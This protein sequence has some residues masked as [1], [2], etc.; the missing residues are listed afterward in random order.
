MAFIIPTILAQGIYT[1]IIGTISSVTIGTCTLVKSI[2]T[3]QNPNVNNIIKK[4]DIERRLHLIQAV[5]NMI[6]KESNTKMANIKLNNLEK[7]EIFEMVGSKIDLMTDPIELCLVYLHEI[8]Q[9]IH[10][11]LTAI[12]KK[13][14]YHNTKWFSAWR[15]LNIEPLVDN[16]KTNSDLLEN[17]FNDLTKISIFLKNK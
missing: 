6:D 14:T 17:R 8:I 15:T 11:D 12:N 4:M 3:H 13:V 10:K 9:E 16:L 5:L 1:G 7:T 2:Y